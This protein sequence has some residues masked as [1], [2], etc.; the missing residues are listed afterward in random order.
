VGQLDPPLNEL[1]VFMARL[2]TAWGAILAAQ[3]L[4]RTMIVE[5]GDNVISLEDQLQQAQNRISEQDA[6][7]RE[8]NAKI[9]E[10]AVKIAELEAGHPDRL[11]Q[12][13]NASCSLLNDIGFDDDDVQAVLEI[14]ASTVIPVPAPSPAATLRRAVANT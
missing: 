13:S 2:R 14:I 6:V 4:D 11:P 9:N 10:Q 12:L 1:E 5:L 3:A 7:I 8:Q